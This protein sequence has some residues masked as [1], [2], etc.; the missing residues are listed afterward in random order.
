VI[1]FVEDKPLNS[2]RLH[3]EIKKSGHSV[4][5]IGSRELLNSWLELRPTQVAALDMIMIGPV[6]KSVIVTR[7]ARKAFSVPIIATVPNSDPEFAIAL[8]DA[9]ADDVVHESVA[10]SEILRR[11][12]RLSRKQVSEIPP[13]WQDGKL[14]VFDDGQDP[15]TN[16]HR[17]LLPRRERK[18]LEFLAKRHHLRVTREQI[19]LSVYGLSEYCV[20]DTAIDAHLCR[21]RKK[22]K[23]EL[24]Y[25]P[26]SSLR[27]LGYRLVGDQR[28]EPL[29]N[30]ASR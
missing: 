22:L 23:L 8:F 7:Q 2:L 26:I 13:I 25:D 1:L 10:L 17:I 19:F 3:A 11:L 15:Q 14:S 27:H 6:D 12:Q 29:P 16:G 24:G 9:G 21:L 20:H 18:I 30:V 4:E 5:L 28:S